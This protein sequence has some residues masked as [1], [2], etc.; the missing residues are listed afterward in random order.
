MAPAAR[1]AEQ[2]HEAAP[3]P[4][5]RREARTSSTHPSAAPSSAPS[6]RRATVRDSRTRGQ[7]AV[8]QLPTSCRP[9]PDEGVRLARMEEA[10]S[11][12]SDAAY[13]A[14]HQLCDAPV[15]GP[16]FG[17]LT[18]ELTV[19]F[20][21][22]ARSPP[23]SARLQQLHNR[24][25][26]LYDKGHIYEAYPLLC[27]AAFTACFEWGPEHAGTLQAV[28]AVTD[29]TH[30]Q[31]NP[32]EWLYTW[33][34]PR[35]VSVWGWGH[36]DTQ[37]LVRQAGMFLTSSPDA[38]EHTSFTQTVTELAQQLPGGLGWGSTVVAPL[39]D[40][41]AYN[42]HVV[43]Q[44]RAQAMLQQDPRPDKLIK[45]MLDR[46][47]AYY[48]SLGPHW[49]GCVRKAGCAGLLSAVVGTLD[50]PEAAQA[51]VLKAKRT[52]Q[53]EL[54]PAHEST[55]V[56]MAWWARLYGPKDSE[57]ALSVQQKA[58][59][60]PQETRPA[61]HYL[62]S[63]FQVCVRAV[64]VHSPMLHHFGLRRI[65]G[66]LSQCAQR[67]VCYC[68]GSFFHHTHTIPYPHTHKCF[69]RHT[70]THRHTHTAAHRNMPHAVNACSTVYC[71]LVSILILFKMP[72]RCR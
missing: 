5:E 48:K 57:K 6:A 36:P 30:H 54:G 38:R 42:R 12:M 31:A 4:R 22:G 37:R 70:Q 24:A 58:L 29:I 15:T 55:L 10:V 35:A 69:L 23:D 27:L 8:G 68:S 47:V 66:Y 60:L 14:F 45:D 19:G 63:S 16:V 28:L 25:M 20:A 3:A 50:G 52:A 59:K 39:P 61:Y 34:L 17:Q 26:Q 13:A 2:R 33:L 53:R 1:K 67:V 62:T 64:R 18:A 9:E 65:Y 32:R 56:L 71:A 44:A 11:T 41:D 7:A 21:P 43:M 46:C 72:S 49:L 40:E 51:L